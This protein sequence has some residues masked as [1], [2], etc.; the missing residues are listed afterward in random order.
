MTAKAYADDES[1]DALASTGT[2]VA[3]ASDVHS[4]HHPRE[5]GIFPHAN[6]QPT[7]IG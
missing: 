4:H 7:E 5:I 6:C 1:F 2:H 3:S